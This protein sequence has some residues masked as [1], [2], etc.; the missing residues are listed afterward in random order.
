MR[1][2][3]GLVVCLLLFSSQAVASPSFIRNDDGTLSLAWDANPTSDNV[4]GYRVHYGTAAGTYQS[5][6]DVGNTTGWPIPTNLVPGLYYFAVSAYRGSAESDLSGEVSTGVN[7]PVD[8]CSP[9]LGSKAVSIFITK[10]ENTSGSVG[11]K[12]RLN[13]QLGSPNSSIVQLRVLVNGVGVDH[14]VAGT[15]LGATGGIWFTTPLA[16]GT[17]TV[18][19]V[20]TNAAACTTTATKDPAGRALTVTVK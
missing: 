6:V 2:W 18:A 19:L 7:Q 13:F 4:D 8:D 3:I 14:P 10:L 5:T 15:D 12:A 9:P 16:P 17:Y 20:A 1:K 11:S